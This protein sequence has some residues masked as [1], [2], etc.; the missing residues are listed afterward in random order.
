MFSKAV[1]FTLAFLLTLGAA[2]ADASGNPPIPTSTPTAT[3]SQPT[4]VVNPQQTRVAI[5]AADSV[6]VWDLKTATLV[7]HYRGIGEV[8]AVSFSADGT[9]LVTRDR[10]GLEKLWPVP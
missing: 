8:V 1:A 5:A 6:K 4:M 3:A 10:S 7:A 9:R 2:M